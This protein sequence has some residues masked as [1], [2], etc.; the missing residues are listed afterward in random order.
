MRLLSGILTA[1]V[2]MHPATSHPIFLTF[3]V[4]LVVTSEYKKW[5]RDRRRKLRVATGTSRSTD[6]LPRYQRWA[7]EALGAPPVEVLSLLETGTGVC[8]V[9]GTPIAAQRSCTSCGAYY[10]RDCW[11][12]N[13]GCARYGCG[14]LATTNTTSEVV[15][16]EH[17]RFRPQGADHSI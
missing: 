15:G 9:C 6:F 3:L 17:L 10:H 7:D 5:R 1:L 2:L 13:G 4:G 16:R 11:E 14:S 12:Y 8:A